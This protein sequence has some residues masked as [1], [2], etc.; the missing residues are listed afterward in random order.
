MQKVTG[1]GG[2][3]FKAKDTKKLGLWYETHLGI[4]PCPTSYDEPVWH[5]QSGET[6]LAPFAEDTDYFGDVKQQWMINFRVIDINAMVSQLQNANIAVEVDSTQYPN[7]HFARLRD[8]EG[9]PIQLWQPVY[10]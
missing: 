7:G 9:N 10:A 3:F 8:P 5:Q 1:I 6:V 4:N 2:F